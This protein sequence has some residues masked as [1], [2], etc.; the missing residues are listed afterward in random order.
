MKYRNLKSY[1][2]PFEEV[3]NV[4]QIKECMEK[5]LKPIVEKET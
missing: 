2:D 3:F 4:S 1:T 5:I